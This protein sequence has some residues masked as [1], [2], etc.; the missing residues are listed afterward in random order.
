MSLE[1]ESISTFVSI[2]KMEISDCRTA[3]EFS[4]FSR[5]ELYQYIAKVIKLKG[6]SK[7]VKPVIV[8]ALVDFVN[9][10]KIEIPVVELTEKQILAKQK[11]VASGHR[12][13]EFNAEQKRLFSQLGSLL[14]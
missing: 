1:L 2:A 7:S 14:D 8:S 6:F 3:V 9:T 12:L 5:E 4:K 13:A 11:K 10:P